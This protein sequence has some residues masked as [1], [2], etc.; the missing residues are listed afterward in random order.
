MTLQPA[1][2]TGTALA[3]SQKPRVSAVFFRQTTKTQY[4]N[5]TDKD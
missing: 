5:E 3:K 4:N 1:K 2:E